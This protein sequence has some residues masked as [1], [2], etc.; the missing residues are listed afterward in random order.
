MVYTL[1]VTGEGGCVSTDQ[2]QIFVR[3]KP[4]IPNTFSPNN[5]GVNDVWKI[6]YLK[7]YP[8][9]NVKIF[10]RTGQ[11]VFQS[12]GYTQPWDG[13]KNGN[14]LPMD[15]YYYIIEPGNGRAPITGFVTIIK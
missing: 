3:R 13:K 5:D 8:A 2:V 6:E 7:D 9:A 4:Q 15:T 12:K 11:Q 1:K 10:T 14:P